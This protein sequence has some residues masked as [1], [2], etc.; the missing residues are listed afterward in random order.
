MSKLLVNEK[1]IVL[2]GQIVAEGMDYLPGEDVVR[3]KDNLIATKVGMASV[4]GRLIRLIS[5]TGCYVPR[6]GDVVI[7]KVTSVGIGGWRMEIGW[8]FEANLSVKEATS[9]FV[10]KGSDLA[11]YFD[12]ADYVVV[13][14]INVANAK[15]I[16]L[17]VKGPSL[18][19]LGPGRLMKIPP[20]KVPRVIGKQGSMISQIKDV[21]GC[22]IVVGQ[23]GLVWLSGEDPKMDLLAAKA[24]EKIV[25]ESHIPGLTD[26]MKIYL[27]SAKNG[28]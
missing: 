28:I 3:E 5:L 9:D 15:I 20:S 11:K 14:I 13:Q 7:G 21:T 8:P 22:K 23:N 12:Y 10:E 16:D 25:A 6:R 19:K 26:R 2:P 1:D 17:T 24:I 18:R 27:E 4:N